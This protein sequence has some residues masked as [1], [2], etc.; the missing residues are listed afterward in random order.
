MSE[1]TPYP[2]AIHNEWIFGEGSADDIGR[3][4]QYLIHMTAPR[5]VEMLG[6]PARHIKTTPDGPA[7][8]PLFARM[9]DSPCETLAPWRG[10]DQE[11]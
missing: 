6:R 7:P 4:R 2:H 9:L 11:R 10:M 1:V 5:F 8:E 3:R